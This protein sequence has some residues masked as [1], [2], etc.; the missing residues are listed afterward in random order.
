MKDLSWSARM[1]LPSRL[2]VTALL[3]QLNEKGRDYPI[4]YVSRALTETETNCSAFQREALSGMFALKKFR[5]YLLS[6]GIE[7]YNDHQALKYMVNMRDPHRRIPRRF[8]YLVEYIF[9]IY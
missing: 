7:L 6:M 8:S 9:E 1:H 2:A 5:R 3:F 4:D